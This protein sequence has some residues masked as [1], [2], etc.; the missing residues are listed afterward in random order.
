MPV[1]LFLKYAIIFL[2]ILSQ[3]VAS[4]PRGR[5]RCVEITSEEIKAKIASNTN[6][7]EELTAKI[8]EL[9]LENKSLQKDLP[10]AEAKEKAEVE[11]KEMEDIVT[12]LKNSGKSLEEIK[13][14]LEG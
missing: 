1:Y 12:L 6:E 2:R 5:K 14:M 3:E 9:R 10:I 11:K 7:I 13:A 8:K 4:M